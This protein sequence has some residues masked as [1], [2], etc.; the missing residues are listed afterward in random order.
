MTISIH[1][2]YSIKSAARLRTRLDRL[3]LLLLIRDSH[4]LADDQILF[5]K[6]LLPIH[7]GLQLVL[8]Q[9]I[10][11]VE[12]AMKIRG[13][14]VLVETPLCQPSTR[15]PAGKVLI[16]SSRAVEISAWRY[17]E[18]STS[19]GKVD[20]LAGGA[21]VF[22]QRRWGEG[23]ED[24][25]VRGP[26]DVWWW[27]GLELEIDHYPKGDQEDDVDGCEDGSTVSCQVSWYIRDLEVGNRHWA[28]C[29]WRRWCCC[30]EELISKEKSCRVWSIL[31]R[32]HDGGQ[33]RRWNKMMLE[34]SLR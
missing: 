11:F 5:Q 22:G 14:H 18:D 27:S 6:L 13:Q 16:R 1:V 3:S 24:D 31:T 26:R 19:D 25:G 10:Q 8:V 15:V 32:V 9:I 23:L 4:Q 7:Q 2:L 28:C 20:G 17:I 12:W 21:V 33:C 29:C 30:D 34:F